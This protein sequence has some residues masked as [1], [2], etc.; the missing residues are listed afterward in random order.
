MNAEGTNPESYAT[1]FYPDGE[2]DHS[3]SAEALG[4][5][6]NVHYQAILRAERSTSG[7]YWALGQAAELL[8]NHLG[9]GQASKYLAKLG[10]HKVRLSKARSI[11]RGFS[12]PAALGDMGVEEAYEAT[13]AKRAANRPRRTRR[14]VDAGGETDEQSDGPDGQQPTVDDLEVFLK[15][16]STRVERLIDVV[17]FLER[18][19]RQAVLPLYRAAMERASVPRPDLGRERPAVPRAARRSPGQAMAA[20]P[21][22]LRINAWTRM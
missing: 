20:R 17:A 22:I 18:E 6:A 1:K 13:K 14:S 21:R 9:R 15:E 4:Q 5:Y 8:R 7:H 3:W 10:I 11:F 2:P 12:T 19:Q 16:V